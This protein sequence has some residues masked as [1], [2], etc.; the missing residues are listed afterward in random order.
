[1]SLLNDLA[2]GCREIGGKVESKF[3]SVGEGFKDRRA[4]GHDAIDDS[5]AFLI[6]HGLAGSTH[7]HQRH[8]VQSKELCTVLEADRARD[9]PR[10]N[11]MEAR[12]PEQPL[13]NRGAPEAVP[14]VLD[15]ADVRLRHAPQLSEERDFI[16]GAPCRDRQSAAV[17]QRTP[18]LRCRQGLVSEKLQPLLA[19]DNVELLSCAE[20][21]RTGVPFT[22][23]DAWRDSACDREHIATNVDPNHVSAITEPLLCNPGY[24]SGSAC[25]VENPIAFGQLKL[26]EREYG[27]RPKQRTY[28][29]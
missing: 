4:L 8:R 2:S 21:Q 22:P 11:L 25:D 1:M 9:Y 12:A 15:G 7:A 5:L 26:L 6:A 17:C 28:E 24:D 19:Y 29:R 23:V 13:E 27:P 14:L 20:G 3:P 16:V 18:H 10:L